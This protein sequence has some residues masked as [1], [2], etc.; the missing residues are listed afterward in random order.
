MHADASRIGRQGIGGKFF[1][2]VEVPCRPDAEYS[3][4]QG[5]GPLPEL[6]PGKVA[7]PDIPGKAQLVKLAKIL[8][9]RPFPRIIIDDAVMTVIIIGVE[10]F[11]IKGSGIQGTI[12]EEGLGIKKVYIGQYFKPGYAPAGVIVEKSNGPVFLSKPFHQ[13]K[14][15]IIGLDKT[16]DH[17]EDLVFIPFKAV[18]RRGSKDKTF[19]VSEQK[20]GVEGIKTGYTVQKDKNGYFFHG[21]F[22]YVE[23]SSVEYDWVFERI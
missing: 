12:F 15:N 21:V 7:D 16:A 1:S 14:I 22:Q 13:G 19:C 6:F 10:F 23:G 3:C 9:R 8:K 5:S 4:R 2:G 20:E 11:S 17:N 18:F